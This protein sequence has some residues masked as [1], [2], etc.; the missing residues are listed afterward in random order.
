[1]LNNLETQDL[2]KTKKT[3]TKNRKSQKLKNSKQN[4]AIKKNPQKT[5]KINISKT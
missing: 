1:M 3:K 5:K 2:K 4:V